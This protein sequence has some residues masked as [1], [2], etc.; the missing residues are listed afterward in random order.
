[1]KHLSI[2]VKLIIMLL[3]ISLPILVAEAL[4][5]VQRSVQGYRQEMLNRT[6]TG[7]ALVAGFAGY[8]LA[9][10]D[11]QEAIA[12]LTN[13]K[14]IQDVIYAGLY[15]KNGKLFAEYKTLPK[16]VNIDLPKKA[17]SCFEENYLFSY[18]PVL[19]KDTEAVGTL[20]IVCDATALQSKITG[21]IIEVLA[22]LIALLLLALVA[23]YYLQRFISKP[24]LSLAG[25]ASEITQAGNYRTQID[26]GERSDEI[27]VLYKS[28]NTML[29]KI[30]TTAV[31][32]EQ[33]E[34][35]EAELLIQNAR[36]KRRNEE[37]ECVLASQKGN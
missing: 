20:F 9:Y 13:L 5:D 31:S 33:M 37:L 28:I 18:R 7:A 3:A 21:R 2:R 32:K 12:T 35:S 24:I 26:G 17:G 29:K 22:A 1:M 25:K 16:G 23:G 27:G 36:L 6:E 10:A 8:D 11:R 4:I 15:D 19:H 30:S 34:E 14:S